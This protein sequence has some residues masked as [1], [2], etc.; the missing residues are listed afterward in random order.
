MSSI[1]T[2]SIRE[3]QS[4]GEL[5]TPLVD[6]VTLYLTPRTSGDAANGRC[7]LLDSYQPLSKGVRGQSL[8]GQVVVNFNRWP[9]CLRVDSEW[10]GKGE[11][12][13]RRVK[14]CLAGAV[15]VAMSID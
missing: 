11:D 1:L 13:D 9:H 5:T 2:H 10:H 8:K 12:T 6:F 4:N 7:T 3:G 14:V 15:I